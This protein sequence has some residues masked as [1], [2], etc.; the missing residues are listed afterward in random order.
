MVREKQPCLE[1][2]LSCPIT[3]GR[4]RQITGRQALQEVTGGG[5]GWNGRAFGTWP[6][7]TWGSSL[8]GS[9]DRPYSR[10]RASIRMRGL[11]LRRAVPSPVVWRENAA[12]GRPC[13]AA[14]ETSASVETRHPA[15][16]G[17][18][19]AHAASRRAAWNH[20]E[21]ATVEPLERFTWTG[22][23]PRL[24]GAWLFCIV[25]PDVPSWSPASSSCNKSVGELSQLMKPWRRRLSKQMLIALAQGD[26]AGRYTMS[27]WVFF[28]RRG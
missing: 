5:Q 26:L 14:C 24:H 13:Q 6:W 8:C 20:V 21:V 11:P 25:R 9:L 3:R 23:S 4:G 16:S 28:D 1:H 12:P 2:R 19:K 10:R 7:K 18:A 15:K 22:P 27:L 17:V